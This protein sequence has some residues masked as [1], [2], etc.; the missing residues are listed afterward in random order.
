MDFSS[1]NFSKIFT[2]ITNFIHMCFKCSCYAHMTNGR[3]VILGSAGRN[4]GAGMSGGFA[5][6]LDE[7]GNFAELS[8]NH[9]MIDLESLNDPEDIAFVK[10]QIDRHVTYTDSPK[11]QWVLDNWEMMLPRFIKVFPKDLKKALSDRMSAEKALVS[12]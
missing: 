2:K 4:F 9:S 10:K 6:V 8:A 11:G 7:M 12:V 1:K 3:V 5:F